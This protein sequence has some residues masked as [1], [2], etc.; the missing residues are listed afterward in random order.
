MA[1]LIYRK[2]PSYTLKVRLYPNREQKEIMSRYFLALE[3]AANMTLYALH[4]HDEAVCKEKDGVFWPDFY[5]MAKKEWLD[6][7][8]EENEL[9]SELPGTSLSSQVGGLFQSDLKKTWEKQGR[10][11]IDAWFD[12]INK[13]GKHVLRYYKG[14]KK[15]TS[16]FLQIPAG[17]I[18]NEDGQVYVTPS[19]KIGRIRIRGWNDSIR[20]GDNG[21][22]SFF[23]HYESDPRKALSCRISQNNC[24]EWY[25]TVVLSDVW[26]PFRDEPDKVH[27]GIDMNLSKD[28]GVV[29]T[30]NGSYANPY[31]K[32]NS[33]DELK[34][35]QKRTS[36]RYGIS[37]EKY[38]KD[39]SAARRENKKRQEN[40]ETELV[41]LPKPS[42]R[43]E[44]ADIKAKKLALKT[45]RRREDYQHRIAA[46]EVTRADLI[47]IEDLDVKAMQKDSNFAE[48]LGDAAFGAQKLKI[49]YKAA[50]KG[51]P[52]S[53]I[54]PVP[55]STLICPVCGCV[56]E[57]EAAIASKTWTC[58]DCH[59][60]QDFYDVKANTVLALAL[61]EPEQKEETKIGK[62]E[63][64]EVKE[65]KAIPK[66]RV[67]D[68]KHPDLLIHYDEE[69]VKAFKNPF[70]VIDRNGNVLDDAQGYGYTTVQAARKAYRYKYG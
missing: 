62:K 69:F 51:I 28:N 34:E 31:Y 43:Y 26:R 68:K 14:G 9:V 67:F 15:K 13:K 45:A 53:V 41:E 56:T 50:W 57:N 18:C 29:S 61:K 47:G 6:R 58:P 11:P 22:L 66:D 60:K 35:F 59:T 46:A 33:A 4:E 5:A 24:D 40:G 38:R 37:N 19:K 42:S 36:R 30:L 12:R 27:V 44:K 32:K 55:S 20:F 63:K 10:L 23:E 21:D 54:D 48:S 3:K 16:Y 49:M 17:H 52:V 7:L 25:L 8:R 64:K 70:V 39:L 2:I 65:P 1:D